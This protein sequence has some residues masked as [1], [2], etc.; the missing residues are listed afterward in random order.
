[1]WPLRRWLREDPW[2]VIFPDLQ[3]YFMEASRTLFYPVE[4]VPVYASKL[5]PGRFLTL[6][7]VGVSRLR[8]PAGFRAP[9]PVAKSDSLL[10]LSPGES[11]FW[12]PLQWTMTTLLSSQLAFNSA[13]DFLLVFP[14]EV[15]NLLS[16]WMWPWWQHFSCQGI[17]W[18]PCLNSWGTWAK[19][20]R[21]SHWVEVPLLKITLNTWS[22]LGRNCSHLWTMPLPVS[23][24]SI[25]SCF[26]LV[27][28]GQA[29]G[30][31][32]GVDLEAWFSIGSF[33]QGGLSRV[34]GCQEKLVS[35]SFFN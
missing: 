27:V 30:T 13:Q 35:V 14:A 23:V 20:E 21:S 9:C 22:C 7:S 4:A 24:T 6:G 29:W 28:D 1:M 18:L 2:P 34:L 16:A 33:P 25:Q 17:W 5:H 10:P 31:D 26:L 12:C 15:S 3:V 19:A 8:N 11:P 32:F